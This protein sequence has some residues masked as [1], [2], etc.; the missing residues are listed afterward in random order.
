MT[1]PNSPHPFFPRKKPPKFLPFLPFLPFL[2][3]LGYLHSDMFHFLPYNLCKT[4]VS[5]KK[6][7]KKKKGSQKTLI[8]VDKMNHRLT[9]KGA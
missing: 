6:K 4:V 9:L 3:N 7:K 8:R 1:G 5:K 2:T